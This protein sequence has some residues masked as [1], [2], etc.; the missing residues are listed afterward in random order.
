V[1]GWMGWEMTMAV[2][3]RLGREPVAAS[4]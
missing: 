2:R 4:R 3:K 1:G